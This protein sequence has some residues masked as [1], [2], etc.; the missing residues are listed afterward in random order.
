M[1]LPLPRQ[2]PGCWGGQVGLEGWVGWDEAG[3]D[4]GL[5]A[6]VATAFQILL[7]A[8]EFT[9][10]TGK[11]RKPYSRLLHRKDLRQ[12]GRNKLLW[13]TP[14]KQ[15]VRCLTSF[16]LRPRWSMKLPRAFMGTTDILRLRLD[17]GAID[18]DVR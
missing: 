8:Y 7:R 17:L 4:E 12:K 5:R 13:M 11:T 9:Q 6:A 15:S 18:G 14:C 2:P 1:C 10:G 16:S 3:G